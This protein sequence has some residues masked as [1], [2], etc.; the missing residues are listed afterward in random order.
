M[1]RAH[2]K[3]PVQPLRR[4]HLLA[5]RRDRRNAPRE[6]AR[7][8]S[9]GAALERDLD[10]GREPRRVRKRAREALFGR[11]QC[12]VAAKGL[13]RRGLGR[14]GRRGEQQP[15]LVRAHAVCAFLAVSVIVLRFIQVVV[16]AFATSAPVLCVA[17][18]VVRRRPACARSRAHARGRAHARARACAAAFARARGRA[19]A[20][21]RA[22]AR[23]RARAAAITPMRA[24]A[25]A[26][27]GGLIYGTA[28][29]GNARGGHR[30]GCVGRCHCR[31]AFP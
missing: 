11:E 22:H 29:C 24:R 6:V 4:A 18:A 14:R 26:S 23:A 21:G 19:Y 27:T 30:G 28:S 9:E 17:A 8:A 5:R 15:Q 12:G 3:K 2:L 31:R 7:V 13:E 25:R 20:R 1:R 16:A 10:L